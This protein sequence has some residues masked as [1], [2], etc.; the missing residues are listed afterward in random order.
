MDRAFQAGAVI[1]H[2]QV[3]RRCFLPGSEPEGSV[4]TEPVAGAK[5]AAYRAGW[6]AGAPGAP[7]QHNPHRHGD[8]EAQMWLEGLRD[9]H[10]SG[11]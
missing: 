7:L 11:N 1:L 10:A 3:R 2:D 4:V 8:P 6:E 9:R 5:S